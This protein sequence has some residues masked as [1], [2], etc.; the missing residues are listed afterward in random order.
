[1]K[2]AKWSHHDGSALFLSHYR[3]FEGIAQRDGPQR[4][5]AA[6]RDLMIGLIWYLAERQG[7]RPTYDLVQLCADQLFRQASQEPTAKRIGD[8][9][10]PIPFR[11]TPG[12][13]PTN[14][15]RPREH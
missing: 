14:R 10:P 13:A 12:K 15:H 4:A 3:L 6:V 11:T 1:V 8:L 9:P 2:K 7:Y 5:Q